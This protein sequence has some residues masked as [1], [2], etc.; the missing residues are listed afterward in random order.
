MGWVTGLV[1]GRKENFNAFLIIA[2]RFR[3]SMRYLRCLKEDIDMDTAMLLWNNI[4]STCG[5]PMIIISDRDPKFTYEF[6]TNIYGM[7]GTKLEFSTAYHPKKD[8]LAERMIQTMEDIFRRFC[9]YGM[10]YNDHEGYTHDWVTLLPEVQLPYN[11]SQHSATGKTPAV[12]EKGQNP[13]LQVENLKKNLLTIHP[14]AKD[15]HEMW[16]RA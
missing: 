1:P 12:V 11:T 8:G 15:F 6:W 4:I 16:K 13:L 9:A 10:E 3:K 7:L 2:H 5:V 14:T